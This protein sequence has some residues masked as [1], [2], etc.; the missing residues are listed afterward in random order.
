MIHEWSDYTRVVEDESSVEV[1][2]AQEDLDVLVPL[3]LW[4]LLYGLNSY[5]VHYHPSRRDNEA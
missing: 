1:C 3:W 2:K 5:W 4:P